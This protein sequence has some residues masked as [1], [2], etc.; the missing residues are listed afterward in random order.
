M[1]NVAAPEIDLAELDDVWKDAALGIDRNLGLDARSV[2]LLSDD[3]TVGLV[4]TL[5]T[6][7]Q[8]A[9]E[10]EASNRHSWRKETMLGD[11]SLK[12]AVCVLWKKS[13]FYENKEVVVTLK[14]GV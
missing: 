11:D 8:F 5:D 14:V 9:V 3:D 10:I 2:L 1:S 4:E 6:L 13:K 7:Q 12:R